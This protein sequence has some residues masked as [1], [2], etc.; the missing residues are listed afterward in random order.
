MV[1]VFRDGRPYARARVSVEWEMCH[2]PSPG[3]I[4]GL[5]R[6]AQ[7]Y[8]AVT[9]YASVSAFGLEAPFPQRRAERLHGHQLVAGPCAVVLVQGG[10]GRLGARMD[11]AALV[12]EPLNE[13]LLGPV[14]L[15]GLLD[16]LRLLQPLALP[17]QAATQGPIQDA[18][19][20]GTEFV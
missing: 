15:G 3:L 13:I 4:V 1:T 12:D 6:N 8:S 20:L 7:T 19:I 5:L 10:G 16:G 18:G 14:S 2:H 11:E 9:P 17:E